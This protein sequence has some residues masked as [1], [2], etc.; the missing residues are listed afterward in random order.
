MGGEGEE[1][2]AGEV[3]SEGGGKKERSILEK[4]RVRMN[5]SNG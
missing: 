1:D 4:H 3:Q 5:R 2:V